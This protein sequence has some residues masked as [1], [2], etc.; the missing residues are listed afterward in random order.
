M[1]A[2]HPTASKV[3]VDSEYQA[4]VWWR[5]AQHG[6]DVEV[7]TRRPSEKGFRVLA[8][9]WVVERTFGW[10][11][12][13]RRLARDYE[14]SPQ[15]SRVMTLRAMANTMSRRIAGESTQNLARVNVSKR[16]EQD[17]P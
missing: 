15:R 17:F 14:A 2:E 10:L 16:I 6:I 1:A 7:V 9:S 3:W 13:H 11:M 8:R 12:Q 4:A 5:G